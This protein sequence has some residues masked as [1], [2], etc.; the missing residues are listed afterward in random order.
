MRFS[1]G[2]GSVLAGACWAAKQSPINVGS[3][4]K[5]M[6]MPHIGRSTCITTAKFLSLFFLRT[7][8]KQDPHSCQQKWHFW[9]VAGI[10]GV[11]GAGDRT[12]LPFFCK[13]L[14]TAT[15]LEAPRTSPNINDTLR[16]VLSPKVPIMVYQASHSSL[17]SDSG[18]QAFKFGAV[19]VNLQYTICTSGLDD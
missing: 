9:G 13:S 16:A 2:A 3:R 7:S 11:I 18:P 10:S 6:C 17:T 1:V 5:Q 14:R 15:F 19:Q 12:N 8:S 4:K